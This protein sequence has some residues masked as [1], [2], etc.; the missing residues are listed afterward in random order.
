VVFGAAIA[1]FTE[2]VSSPFYAFFAFAVIQSGLLSGFHRT[3]LVTVVSLLLYM[4]L[5]LVSGTADLNFYVMR[6]VYLAIVGYLVAYMGQQRLDLEAQIHGLA[7]AEQRH[8][9]ARD[10]HDGWAQAL[11]GINLR[12]ETSRQLFQRGGVDVAISD[13][14]KLQESVKREY[15]ELRTYMRSLV[16]LEAQPSAPTAGADTRF[17][18]STELTGSAPFVD[19]VLQVL[20]EG[21]GNVARHARATFA[22]LRVQSNGRVVTITIDD[23]G[24]GFESP[25]QHPWSIASRVRE[26]NGEMRVLRGS[27]PGAHLVIRLPQG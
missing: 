11:A 2:G 26:L 1:L 6:P 3:M 14:E 4:S 7:A 21:V 27:L 24:H 20:R 25:D 8:R 5:F 23:D 17:V 22:A 10:L 13:L 9:I 19:H 12:I 15:D 18:V 16:G